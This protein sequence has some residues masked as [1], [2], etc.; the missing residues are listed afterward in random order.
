[1]EPAIGRFVEPTGH[2]KAHAHQ[3]ASN[4]PSMKC[5]PRRSTNWSR[6]WSGGSYD[7]AQEVVVTFKRD[8][9][10]KPA[11]KVHRDLKQLGL[12]T[13]NDVK[14]DFERLAGDLV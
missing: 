11:Q 8:L 5:T 6:S 13:P 4:G 14:E 1:L 9:R 12:P 2:A 3:P 7:S 10:S